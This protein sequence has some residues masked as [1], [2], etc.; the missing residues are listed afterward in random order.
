MTN[1]LARYGR[2][3]PGRVPQPGHTLPHGCA[4]LRGTQ[5]IR[6]PLLPGIE[7]LGREGVQK[8]RYGAHKTDKWSPSQHNI[9]GGNRDWRGVA[10]EE[11]GSEAQEGERR[12]SAQ[13]EGA[14]GVYPGE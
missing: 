11:G 12:Q 4:A 3:R 2:Y 10:L 5:A 9:G 14:D 1:N 7:P 6:N 8:E 13:A